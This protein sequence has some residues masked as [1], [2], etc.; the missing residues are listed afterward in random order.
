MRAHFNTSLPV[1]PSFESPGTISNEQIRSVV[2]EY[3]A[4]H[5]AH[6]NAAAAIAADAKPNDQEGTEVG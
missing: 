3:L 5:A 6:V 2:E 4:A 1:P